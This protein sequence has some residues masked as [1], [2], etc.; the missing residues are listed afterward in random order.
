MDWKS[1]YQKPEY[2]NHSGGREIP[3]T[4]NTPGIW[5][6]LSRIPVV[7]CENICPRGRLPARNFKKPFLT[8]H[9]DLKRKLRAKFQ[10]SRT[11]HSGDI[12]IINFVSERMHFVRLVDTLWCAAFLRSSNLDYF[13]GSLGYSGKDVKEFL[14]EG[15]GVRMTL[16]H[17]WRDYVILHCYNLID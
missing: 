12:G 5:F 16:R 17:V 3:T 1:C 2:Q 10:L 13:F 9:L 7:P 6:G 8:A 11:L 15:S 14:T 4:R